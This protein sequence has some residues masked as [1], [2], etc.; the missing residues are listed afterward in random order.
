MASEQPLPT[1]KV[2]VIGS[3][4]VDYTDSDES[5]TTPELMRRH[6][7]EVRPDRKWLLERVALYPNRELASRLLEAIERTKPDVLLYVPGSNTFA[8]ESVAFAIRKRWPALYGPAMRLIGSGKRAAGGRAQGSDSPRG[9]LF[10]LPRAV[11]RSVIGTAPLIE[12]D[13]AFAA[14]RELFRRLELLPDLPVACRLAMGHHQQ[15]EQAET[16]RARTRD[17]NALLVGECARLGYPF[18]DIREAFAERGWPYS[19]GP[20]RLHEDLPTRRLS[21][22]IWAETVLAALSRWAGAEGGS[23]RAAD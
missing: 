10:R 20:D 3:S 7:Q 17:F 13:V 16:I 12:P 14:T 21:A 2:L 1:C 4:Q 19:L 5:A 15:P 6:L 11:A 22:R 18:V 8:E 9:W 23:D